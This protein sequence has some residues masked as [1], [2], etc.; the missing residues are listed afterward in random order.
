MRIVAHLNKMVA[1]VLATLPLTAGEYDQVMSAVR[2]SWPEKTQIAIVCDATA[3]KGAI[4]A[5]AGASGGMKISVM[6]VKGPQDIGKTVNALSG[7]RPDLVV[8]IAG[9]RLA[10]DGQPGA[11]FIIQRMMSMKVPVVATTEG[12]VKQGAVFGGGPG[13][14][15]KIL[16]NPKAAALAGVSI[17]DGASP[18]S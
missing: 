17:P 4:A 15:S 18:V 1:L 12:G 16:G 6:D 7:K 11:T 3:S 13:T 8:L 10:G 5:L 14:G 9:D 2:K